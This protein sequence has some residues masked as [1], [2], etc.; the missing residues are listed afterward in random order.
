MKMSLVLVAVLGSATL[1]VGCGGGSSG[2]ETLKVGYLVDSPVV[3]A[4]YE[5]GAIKSKT[6]NSGKFECKTLPVTFKIGGWTV[7]TLS[8]MTSDKKVYPQDLV[9][10]PRDNFTNPTVVNLTRMLQSLDDDGDITKAITI[11][12]DADEKL[13]SAKGDLTMT[14]LAQILGVS[15]DKIVDENVAIAHLKGNMPNSGQT[16]DGS[17]N[18]SSD[19]QSSG[20]SANNGGGSHNDNQGWTPVTSNFTCD[21]EPYTFMGYTVDARYAA[22][23]AVKVECN[24]Q[25]GGMNITAPLYKLEGVESIEVSK[26]HAI[27]KAVGTSDRFGSFS[28]AYVADFDE[29]GG[30]VKIKEDYGN[31]HLE[32]VETYDTPLPQTISSGDEVSRLKELS[33]NA[34]RISTT[35]PASYYDEGDDD[36]ENELELE[37]GNFTEWVDIVVTDTQN[38]V[39]KISEEVKTSK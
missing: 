12:A 26:I 11:R 18:G 35:C 29:N 13:S 15:M 16:S 30:K 7:G 23:G 31:T 6:D 21:S 9:G 32:C 14:A 34:N 3:G 28:Y 4:T 36:V 22:E 8:T 27:T 24:K 20:G 25:V 17:S 5:C 10:V 33:S 19:G 39:H 37:R 1:F 38:K 2:K